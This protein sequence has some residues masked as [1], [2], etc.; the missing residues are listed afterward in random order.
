MKLKFGLIFSFTMWCV[1]MVGQTPTLDFYS[2]TNEQGLSQNSVYSISQSQDGFIWLG[3]IHGLNRFD[4]KQFQTYY[5]TLPDSSSTSAVIYSLFIDSENHF[6]VGTAEKLFL[7]DPIFNRFQKVEKVLKGFSLPEKVS[8]SQV[9]EDGQNRIWV[10]TLAHGLFCYDKKKEAVSALLQDPL[11]RNKI[12]DVVVNEE[13]KVLVA[14]ENALFESENNQLRILE[15]YFPSSQASLNIRSMTVQGD[16]VILGIHNYGLTKF[17]KNRNNQ[18][19][20]TD[21][22]QFSFLKD[23]NDLESVGDSI[24]WIGSRSNGV[25]K[26]KGAEK[27]W[28]RDQ[29]S[30]QYLGLKSNFI[31]DIF[32]DTKKRIWLGLSG[33]GTAVQEEK[34]KIFNLLRPSVI[35]NMLDGDNMVFG[36]MEDREGIIYMGS[37]ND[38]LKAFFPKKGK[39]EYYF[40]SELPS[41]ASNIYTIHKD[42]ELLWLATWAG[43]C[44]FNPTSGQFKYWDAPTKNASRLYA[45]TP[46]DNGQLLLG[47]ENGLY[48]FDTGTKTFLNVKDKNK[49][50]ENEILVTRYFHKLDNENILLATTDRGLIKYNFKEGIFIDFPKLEK[51]STACRH[52]TSNDKN[53]FLAT[54]NGVLQINKIDFSLKK[55]W[56]V[57]D[58]LANDFCYAIGLDD[59]DQLWVST[60]GGLSK[61]DLNNNWVKNFGLADGLQD[62]EFNTA[63]FLKTK[64]QKFIFGGINGFNIFDPLSIP[65]ST[66]PDKPK[67]IAIKVMNEPYVHSKNHSYIESMDLKY[68]QNFL[69]IEFISLSEIKEDAIQYQYLLEGVNDQWVKNG[70]R[71]LANFTNLDPGTYT[72]KVRASVGG[73]AFSEVNDQLIINIK[74]AFWSTWWFRSLTLLLIGSLAY[75]FYLN[76]V[77]RFKEKIA[78]ERK[79]DQLENMALRLQMNPHFLFNTLNSIK[80]YAV[81]RDKDETSDFISEFSTLIRMILEN[82]RHSFITLGEELE[83]IKLYVTVEQKRLTDSFNFHLEIEDG[84]GLSENYIPPMLIQPFVENAIWHGLMHKEGEKKLSIVLSKKENGYDCEIIDNGIGREQHATIK[85]SRKKK[86]LATNIAIDRLKILTQSGSETSQIEIIDLYNDQKPS[87]TKVLLKIRN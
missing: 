15:L 85:K 70:S 31:L 49:F 67:V 1:I 66:L 25:I 86:S 42:D 47:G 48:V 76:R 56:R 53:I 32:Q 36:M 55:H 51:R 39:L 50:L 58:G 10:S 35:S 74:P 9:V 4:G 14:T 73:A 69:S 81:F 52:I 18:Y 40:D 62:L 24:V 27:K 7:F 12:T 87:G 61:I 43:L 19:Q 5:P 68:D 20:L 80:H 8:I 79:V 34:K 77:N 72:F 23:I 26:L 37:L 78:I 22:A 75:W 59:A 3:T 84:L 33:G 21:Q 30:N 13:G 28:D 44:S 46:I 45:I 38:G 57:I 64:D 71:T 16:E 17:R 60:N 63:S 65:K 6:F 29:F 11:V 83:M 41:Q 82:S 2:Y 54:E